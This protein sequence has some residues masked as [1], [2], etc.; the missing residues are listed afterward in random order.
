MTDLKTTAGKI[1]D[2]HSKLAQA[3]AP[4]GTQTA[5][6]ERVLSL[7]DADSFVET[8]ALARHRSKDFGREHDRPYTDGV[9]TGYGTVDGRKVCV[10]SLDA[11]IFDGTLGEV[12][13]E[14]IVKVYDMAIKTGVPLV[15]LLE[16]GAPRAQEGIVSLAFLG[17]IMQRATQASGLV[18]Q[19]TVSFGTVEFLPQALGDLTI[20]AQADSAPH[21]AE[22]ADTQSADTPG[23]LTAAD[24][25]ACA[26]QV[27]G[28][29]P[30][31]NRAEAPRAAAPI[32]AGAIADNIREEDGVLNS[33]VDGGECDVEQIIT[34]VAESTLRLSPGTALGRIEG[35]S[36]GL[37]SV[38]E[39]LD[40]ATARF[41][42]LC[43]A[44]NIPLVTFVDAPELPH[45]PAQL[46][47]VAHAF[48]AAT[49]GKLTVVVRRALGSG[50]VVA[51]S[52]DLG[53]DLAY[54]WPT[55]EIAVADATALAQTLGVDDASE[56]LTPYQAAE[57]GLVDAVIEPATTRGYLIEGLRLL[58]RKYVPTPPKKLSNI[59]L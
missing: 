45:S 39:K 41:I 4:Q 9:I 46:A 17:R 26:K 14:K 2:L 53:A 52:K 11:T 34:T 18:P 50:Y 33:L 58:E 47:Q 35:R 42:R 6:R 25:I 16:A 48:A 51:G 56:F 24:P 40:P 32:M 54:A 59:I 8:D 37:I 38:Q 5:A 1:E 30:S 21:A 20:V 55:A 3:R 29:L 43:D 27:L 12:T 15:A 31:N 49:V 23:T 36:V 19:I 44:F 10:Y 28:L 22:S 7:L 57:R 13:G